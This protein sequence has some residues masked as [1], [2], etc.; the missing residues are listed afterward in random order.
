VSWGHIG[1]ILS[2]TMVDEE[3]LPR[4]R[5]MMW[6]IRIINPDRRQNKGW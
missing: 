2:Q 1:G 3:W 4:R 5:M 6:G